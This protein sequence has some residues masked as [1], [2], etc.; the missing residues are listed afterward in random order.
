MRLVMK[1]EYRFRT[2]SATLESVAP[3]EQART[4]LARAAVVDA[5]R[6]LFLERGYAA[7][8]ID[9]ISQAAGVPE[10]TV[11]RLFASKLGI[12]KSLFDVSI[13]GDSEDVPLP[14]RPAIREVFAHPDPSRRIAGFATLVTEINAR[15]G[16]LYRILLGAS[17]AD[18]QAA[19]LLDDLDRQRREGQL[20]LVRS[21]A[22]SLAPGL[23]QRTAADIV[24]AIASPEVH[25]LLVVGRGWRP[26]RFARW[27]G[28]ALA[29]QLLPAGTVD[30]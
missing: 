24:H 16:P 19:T 14:R 7:T 25:D 10:P 21:L 4:R 2:E 29:A 28:E 27:L 22:T 1:R 3:A 11:Y 8:T 30:D 9:A 12:L 20:A 6:A 17:G 23:S 13:A 5:A 18:P 15:V 26:D